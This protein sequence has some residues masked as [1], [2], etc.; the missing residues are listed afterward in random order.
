M[1]VV[2]EKRTVLAEPELARVRVAPFLLKEREWRQRC[3]R[4]VT[5]EPLIF[6]VEVKDSREWQ[7]VSYREEE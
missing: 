4:I 7:L 2:A 3:T 6:S 5:G 1:A